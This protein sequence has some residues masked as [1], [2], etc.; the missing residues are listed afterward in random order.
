MNKS[1]KS[2]WNESTGSWVAVS[3]L[4]TGRSK[5]KRAKTAI[6]KAI[7]TQIAVGG[8]SL[9][10]ASVAMAGDPVKFGTGATVDLLV[11]SA[12]AGTHVNFANSAG[13]ARE[14]INVAAGTKDTSAVNLS[15]L[16][17]VVAGLG[18]GAGI[19]AAG[20]VT[21]PAY[22]IQ[23]STFNNA[24]D[25][26]NKIDG[27]LTN[28]TSTVD[29]ITAETGKG[30]VAQD[31]TTGNI[32][33]GSLTGGDVV[34][35]TGTAGARKITGVA[36][37][38][39]DV[40]SLDAINGS[41]LNS[42][43]SQM[44]TAIGGGMQVDSKTGAITMPAFSVGGNTVYNVGDAITNLDGRTTSNANNLIQLQD[45]VTNITAGGGVATPN[46]VAYDTAAHDKLTLVGTDGGNTKLTGLQD[47]DLSNTSTDAVTGKQLN[48]TNAEVASLS[49]TVQNIASTGTT[50]IG[51][52][53][54]DGVAGTAGAAGANGADAIAMGDNASASGDHAVVIGGGATGTADGVVVMAATPVRQVRT[55]SL[56]VTVLRL[57]LTTQ[58]RWAPI[59][60]LIVTTPS[61]WVLK[62]MSVR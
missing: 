54:K 9:A 8:M 46:A 42:A 36:A 29:A 43:T 58:S 35:M 61:R 39:L 14:L 19:D 18:G 53:G 31:A 32:M 30:L 57:R 48:A 27:S 52:N 3:E 40:S 2:V 21:G 11:G 20:K 41:Q 15:Q 10:G 56:L 26:F 51:I 28:L 25:A 50:T 34:D 59:R 23:K 4:A 17:P 37:G 5:S 13:A 33:V 6:S 60:W 49:N 44:A 12:V 16:A 55:R 7:L 62:V 45:Q 22:T 47:G 38:S 24:G 1:Y